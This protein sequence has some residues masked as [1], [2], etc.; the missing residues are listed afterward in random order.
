MAHVFAESG[1]GRTTSVGD[2]R[3]MGLRMQELVRAGSSVLNGTLI[4]CSPP[5]WTDS[6]RWR[7]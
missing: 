1:V 4:S 7:R 2:A 5:R 6:P 3:V